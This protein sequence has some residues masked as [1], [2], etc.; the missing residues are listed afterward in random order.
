MEALTKEKCSI[1]DQLQET[2]KKYEKVDKFYEDIIKL[3]D[4]S[5]NDLTQINKAFDDADTKFRRLLTYHKAIGEVQHIQNIKERLLSDN[6]PQLVN[7]ST[8]TKID[9]LNKSTNTEAKIIISLENLV[10]IE[11]Q[12]W[13]ESIH[14]KTIAYN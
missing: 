9:M 3:K 13:K 10:L 7:T 2:R 4:K 5:I 14:P 6:K 11:N 8:N 12:I 1:N